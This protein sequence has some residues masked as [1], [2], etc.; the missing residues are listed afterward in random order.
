MGWLSFEV[1]FIIAS[2]EPNMGPDTS[3]TSSEWL[4]VAERKRNISDTSVPVGALDGKQRK[5]SQ[6][7]L[8]KH[9]SCQLIELG[10]PVVELFLAMTRFQGL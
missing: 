4:S 6:T 5:P 2:P 9:G 8:N 1:V 7:S 3:Q 10:S